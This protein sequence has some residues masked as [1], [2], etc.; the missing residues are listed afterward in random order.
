M[1]VVVFLDSEHKVFVVYI[2][3]LGMDLGEEMHS[4]KKTQIVY[5]KVDKAPTKVSSKYI[6]FENVFLQ[7]LT[8]ELPYHTKINDHVSDLVDDR[9]P[10]YGTIY[11]L[12]SVELKILKA[13]I[14][15]NPANSFNIS[16]KSFLRVPMLFGKKLADSLGLYVN[17]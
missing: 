6:D 7:K 17:Y 10:P 4:S 1:F 14:K 11:S 3:A 12:G 2:V 8:M 5:I 9:E 15:N 16:S 13:Y